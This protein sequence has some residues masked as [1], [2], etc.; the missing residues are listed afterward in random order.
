MDVSALIVLALMA[1]AAT[2]VLYREGGKKSSNDLLG[3]SA[4]MA[5]VTVGLIV[6]AISTAVGDPQ[7]EVHDQRRFTAEMAPLIEQIDYL[8]FKAP[9]GYEMS[10]PSL[11]HFVGN[12]RNIG[13]V[14]VAGRNGVPI[15]MRFRITP[16]HA[17]IGCPGDDGSF[18]ALG[19]FTAEMFRSAPSGCG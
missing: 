2:G 18:K 4:A 9:T 3:G 11:Y 5:V 16:S 10:D 8:G 12:N 6:A 19:K 1:A 15:R 7:D 17:D 14:E 13:T